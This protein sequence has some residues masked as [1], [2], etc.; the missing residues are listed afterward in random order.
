MVGG[1]KRVERSETMRRWRSWFALGI[2]LAALGAAIV[3]ARPA[4]LRS[5]RVT[6][7]SGSNPPCASIALTYGPGARPQCV[8]IDVSGAHGATGSATVGSDQEF[9]EVP[10]AGKAGGPYRVAATAVYRVGGVPVM[11]HEVSGR[12]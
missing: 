2:G 12:S 5:A 1:G 7:L 3:G 4:R 8:V 9:I 6:C 11:R 10:L